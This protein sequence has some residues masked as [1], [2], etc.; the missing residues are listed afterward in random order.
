MKKLFT[1]FVISF[2]FAILFHLPAQQA[3]VFFTKGYRATP[4]RFDL[5]DPS[6]ARI[7]TGGLDQ[8]SFVLSTAS[9]TNGKSYA[10]TGVSF[11]NMTMPAAFTQISFTKDS[12][13][14]EILA[15]Y[16]LMDYLY[17]D[18]AYDHSTS[19]L[20]AIA[21]SRSDNSAWGKDLLKVN[22]TEGDNFAT[23]ERVGQFSEDLC[24]FAVDY[25]GNMYGVGSSGSFYLI[26]KQTAGL[27]FIGSTG[28][29]VKR[30]YQSMEFDHGSGQLYWTASTQGSENSLYR[31]DLLTGRASKVGDF[32]TS[33]DFVNGLNIPF[34]PQPSVPDHVSD[35]AFTTNNDVLKLSFTCPEKDFSGKSLAA[36]MQV[37]IFRDG[38]SVHVKEDAA[39][40]ESVEVSLLNEPVGM[41][42]YRIVASNASGEGPGMSYRVI[43]GNDVPAQTA[44]VAFS[45]FEDSVYLTWRSVKDGKF[46]GN[47][48]IASLAYRVT[49]YPDSVV[50]EAGAD[51]S[52]V[53]RS[54]SK[55]DNYYYEVMAYT[56]DGEGVPFRVG[57]VM[58]GKPY[59]GYFSCEF[60]SAADF[61]P[62]TV[63]DADG[64]FRT[65]EYGSFMKQKGALYRAGTASNNDY[66]VM[67]PVRLKAGQDYSLRYDVGTLYYD[68]T[69]R[70]EI[71]IGSQPTAG[72]LS[73][74]IAT[75][76]YTLD[77]WGE[78]YLTF[79]VE[80]DGVYYL[81]FRSVC[82]EYSSG[83]F[84][85]NIILQPTGKYSD[86]ACEAV[87]GPGF[88]R[89]GVENDLRVF[90]RNVGK[91]SVTSCRLSLIDGKGNM[92]LEP[93]DVGSLPAG[94]G[95]WMNLSFVPVTV[96]ELDIR[97]VVNYSS[98]E[99]A[100][101]DT[102]LVWNVEV[103]P[104][105][106]DEMPMPDG[107][108]R[109]NGVPIHLGSSSS[110]SQFIVSS[111]ELGFT[112]G[113]ITHLSIDYENM[114]GADA[115][116][117]LAIYLAN[118]EEN[119]LTEGW[120]EQDRFTKVY[121]APVHFC[122]TR[123]IV[124]IELTT[125]FVYTG[126]NVCVMVIAEPYSQ[127]FGAMHYWLS[128][129]S[130]NVCRYWFYQ[131]G[132]ASSVFDFSQ[133]GVLADFSPDISLRIDACNGG[134][135]SGRVLKASDNTPVPGARVWVGG[136]GLDV[137]TSSDG[138]WI[139]PYVPFSTDTIDLRVE[140][141]SF[142]DTVLSFVFDNDT[143]LDVK[144]ENRER[145]D[146]RGKVVDFVG[147]PISGAQV[148]ISGY[149]T[150]TA[151]T[152]ISGEFLLRDCYQYNNYLLEVYSS[153]KEIYERKGLV[154][155]NPD[156]DAGQI[157]LVDKPYAPKNVVATES[158]DVLTVSWEKTDSLETFRYDNGKVYLAYGDEQ[159]SEKTVLGAVFRNPA[160]L[161][162]MSWMTVPYY[163]RLHSKV[164]VFVFALDKQ[165]MPT[166]TLLYS[167]MDV[168]NVDSVWT[169]HV[170]EKEI[171]APDGFMLALSYKQGSDS[172][173]SIANDYQDPSVAGGYRFVPNTQYYSSDYTTG[174]FETIESQGFSSSMFIR[175]QG[176]I[177]GL[178]GFESPENGKEGVDY[179]EVC[180]T[181]FTSGE[182]W[183]KTAKSLDSYQVWR[184][185]YNDLQ[186]P[187]SWEL[188]S[189][190]P[191]DKYS[192]QDEDWTNLE[193]GM[194]Y[195]AVQAVYSGNSK[196]EAVVSSLVMKD[197]LSKVTF[198]VQSNSGE[199]TQGV[200]LNLSH[201]EYGDVVYRLTVGTSQNVTSEMLKG[202]YMLH[203]S[204]V[205]GFE[206]NSS[207][208]DVLEDEEKIVLTLKE[209]VCD[210]VIEEVVQKTSETC[211]MR[212]KNPCEGQKLPVRYVL[213]L[214]GDSVG[215]TTSYSFIFTQLSL[216]VHSFGVQ[217]VYHTGRST[218][219]TVNHEIKPLSNQEWNVGQL[220]LYP[221]PASEKVIVEGSFWKLEIID[222]YGRVCL[223]IDAT[224]STLDVQSLPAG[225]YFVRVYLDNGGVLVEKLIIR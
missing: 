209:N 180:S 7:I 176:E 177:T 49:R 25:A 153:G 54:I 31:V 74:V 138:E 81:A 216:G 196:S 43:V 150:Y 220:V 11:I 93:V 15:V 96:G 225:L 76:K 6:S 3:Y 104:S 66:L 169:T 9:L 53:D 165:G 98:D 187:D 73:K 122:R 172:Y 51:T 5:S 62:F 112:A 135:L 149:D 185:P 121:D 191:S 92:L 46:G 106:M 72:A 115:D 211:E 202:S 19:T 133:S 36:D 157:V 102:S 132:D 13:L 155:D 125:P 33:S 83:I 57:P 20:Y 59:D 82:D 107:G 70:M 16:N 52:L 117:P 84:V 190:V 200:I 159:G 103:Y 129:S 182:D 2:L 39:P 205:L 221:N 141:Y 174:E 203:T 168:P 198:E 130:K 99:Q 23:F 69:E 64:D 45:A 75:K 166:S 26:D 148:R 147:N 164:N 38:V 120:I 42:L 170:F 212:W 40:G 113:S 32:V 160:R 127:F 124:D 156:S 144:L 35:F 4:Q 140:A 208:I 56:D 218:I 145:Y 27:S 79:Q 214:D 12:I 55:L 134:E 167:K 143:V 179:G 178:W 223:Q 63:V 58:A 29:Q 123:N 95:S 151:L 213:F 152:D 183:S 171:L 119:N 193:Q 188:V 162:S 8:A 108:I 197:M 186:T 224:Q 41:H 48:D 192:C 34:E 128:H 60:N 146:V 201:L 30:N 181:D 78:D 217:A 47:I 17:Y 18:M 22:L 67:P 184:I 68:F 77:P 86:L 100:L 195:Y 109:Q 65:W 97:A 101:N 204:G 90:V 116:R 173:L 207:I 80:Q 189:E 114:N 10:Y 111:Q 222:F 1:F 163:G 206:E 161:T 142:R 44:D 131:N 91:M 50:Y 126:K 194:Y 199:S 85:S 139:F 105:C 137:F 219:K 87:K 110:A 37:E 24:A 136:I 118:V 61:S 28:V 154:V 158:D 175:A 210:P 215:Q 88:L 14:D 71:C 89:S 21:N 94:R